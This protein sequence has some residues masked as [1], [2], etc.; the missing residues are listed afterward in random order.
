MDDLTTRTIPV[1]DLATYYRNPRRGD[2]DVIAGSLESLGQYRPIVVNEGTRTGRPLE[3]LA[4]NH[5]LLA[6]R[7]LGWP[8]IQATMVDVDDDAAARIVLVDN[9]S[10][11][12]AGYDDTAL[13]DLLAGLDGDFDGTGYTQ[14]DLDALQDA[15][16]DPP[17]PLAD[18]DDAPEPPADPVTKPGSLWR[19]G[20]HRVLCGD[21]TS[22]ADVARLLDGLTPQALIT[23]PPYCS[24]GFQEAGRSQGSIGSGAKI[25]ARI[26]N[27]TLSTRGYMALLKSVMGARPAPIAYVFTDWRMWV[28]LFDVVESSGYG[29]RS[30]IVWD[31]ETPGMGVGWRSQHELIM[32]AT[33]ATVKFD[34]HKAIGN[35]I[36]LSRSGNPLHPTQKP[37]DLITKILRVTDMAE[38]VYDPFAGSG[39][40]LIACEQENRTALLVELDPRHV[41]VICRRWQQATGERPRL[42]NGSEHDF[43]NP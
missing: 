42:D 33:R 25:K 26:A 23:D 12:L 38:V 35:V 27:D 7:E 11:D 9:R 30:M 41:D 13:A 32:Y 2:I 15:L 20:R 5:C 14:D 29:V 43:V 8:T 19:L 21:A 10:S 4:G 6:A 40:T 36:A 34:G 3:V 17:E 37:V 31:K 22:P 28:N 24:G 16:S 18:P 39:T 1:G